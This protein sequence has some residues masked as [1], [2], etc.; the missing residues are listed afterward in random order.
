MKIMAAIHKLEA[1][2]AENPDLDT[3][4]DELVW[5]I[6]TCGDEDRI[7]HDFHFELEVGSESTRLKQ[8][9]LY[10]N[11]YGNP[12][13]RL[14]IYFRFGKVTHVELSDTTKCEVNPQ[15]LSQFMDKW[16]PKSDKLER[17]AVYGN[18]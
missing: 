17:D 6:G 4:F 12:C 2:K 7:I 18:N 9:C 16:F 10:D 11:R 5:L 15:A 13:P 1:L 14:H 8:L 3:A